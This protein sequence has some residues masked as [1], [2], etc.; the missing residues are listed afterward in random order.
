MALLLGNRTAYL[1]LV[2]AAAR[3]GAIAVPLNARLTAPELR[4]LLDDCTPRVLVHEADARARRRGPPARGAAAPP[5]HRCGV[6]RT[7][8][9]ARS[10]G[11]RRA[12]AIE[13]VTPDDPMLLMYTSG[14]TGTPKGALLPHRKTL[15]N[16][17]NAAALLRADR[18]RTAC[19]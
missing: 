2:F 12:H 11:A 9:S 10:R 17:L 13:P 4:G 16:S 14:T 1:E 7:T 5:P 8:T 3:L 18:R 6:P 15:Y 19:S